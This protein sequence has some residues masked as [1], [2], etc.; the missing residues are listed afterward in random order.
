MAPAEPQHGWKQQRETNQHNEMGRDLL[1]VVSAEFCAM[2]IFVFTCVGC[3][4]TNTGTAPGANGSPTQPNAAHLTISLCFGIT[5]FVLAHCFGHIS[6]AH[7]NPAVTAGLM[8]GNQVSVKKGL[9][10]M[11]AQCLASITASGILM[12]VMGLKMETMGGFN[13]LTGPDDN[14]IARGFIG[15]MFM[16]FVLM[17]TVYATIDPD[18]EATGLGPLA[19]GLAVGVAHF[20]LVPI[21]GCGIN[22]ARS[23]GPAIFADNE[24]AREDLWVFLI[25]P[26][27]GS[28]LAAVLYP[29]WFANDNFTVVGKKDKVEEIKKHEIQKDEVQQ[30]QKDA[31]IA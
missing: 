30:I 27:L 28:A 10:Y 8:I 22:P 18:R 11:L 15:E 19:I 20:F 4:L 3:A 16:T 24:A 12:A 31:E 21:T 25:A 7:V 6:G 26:F 14:K 13:A 9:M 5:I 17:F 29:F 23:L 2:F 1:R